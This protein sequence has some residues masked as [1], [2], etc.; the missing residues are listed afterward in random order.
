MRRLRSATLSALT[1]GAN[2]ASNQSLTTAGR[3]CLTKQMMSSASH[4]NDQIVCD[5]ISEEHLVERCEYKLLGG[6]R[7]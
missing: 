3:L 2:Q 4:L 1:S 7:G 6:L 5:R